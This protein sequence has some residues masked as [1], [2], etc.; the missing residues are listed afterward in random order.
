MQSAMASRVHEVMLIRF[1]LT[2]GEVG[3]TDFRDSGM[4]GWA[5]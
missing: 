2:L 5:Y 3:A 1:V 4:S